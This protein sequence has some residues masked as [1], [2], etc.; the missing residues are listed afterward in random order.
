[1]LVYNLNSWAV[2]RDMKDEQVTI[3][4]LVWQADLGQLTLQC[5]SGGF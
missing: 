3:H 1:M 5:G 2:I 4:Q